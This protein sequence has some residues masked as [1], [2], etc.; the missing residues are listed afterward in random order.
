[1]RI[2]RTIKKL[3]EKFT[4]SIIDVSE[5]R[6]ET[7]VKVKK[8]DIV[9]ISRFLHDEPELSYDYL[10][11]VVGVDYFEKKPRFEVV[12]HLYSIKN[13]T[14]LRVKVGVDENDLK[15]DTVTTIWESANWPEREC[16]DLLGIRFKDHPDLRRILL[17]DDWTCFPLRKDYPLKG[18]DKC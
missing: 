9:K 18:D 7:T 12:Y 11:D 1:M 15:L 2:K 17:P 8:S 16:Y 6:G 5:F 13:N 3:K 14:R 10:S 4:E